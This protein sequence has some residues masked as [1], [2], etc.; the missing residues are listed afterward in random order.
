MQ[1]YCLFNNIFSDFTVLVQDNRL[2]P[3]QLDFRPD[4]G[5]KIALVM[6]VDDFSSCQEKPILFVVAE[7]AY[8]GSCHSKNFDYWD[9]EENTSM[10]QH[11]PLEL[12]TP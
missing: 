9:P 7:R 1:F 2:D 3:L 5:T 6:L 10:L 12:L 4:Y 8:F 11:R